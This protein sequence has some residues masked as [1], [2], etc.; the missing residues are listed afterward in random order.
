MIKTDMNELR[1]AM[2]RVKPADMTPVQEEA[3]RSAKSR[4]EGSSKLV[5]DLG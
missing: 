3:I 2:K 5:T 4:L 1:K